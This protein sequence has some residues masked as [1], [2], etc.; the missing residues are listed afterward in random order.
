MPRA[1]LIQRSTI[2]PP[3]YPRPGSST[4]ACAAC[5]RV[6]CCGSAMLPPSERSPIQ[7]T[8]YACGTLVAGDDP[9]T[10]VVGPDGRVHAF[11]NLYVADGSVLPRS[12]RVNPAL[13][14]Y[15]WALRV[16]DLLASR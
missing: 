8:A 14:I 4:S 12:G 13:T 15:A 2:T 7:S 6:T 5:S 1:R 3:G 11:E 9:N 16:G 10:S